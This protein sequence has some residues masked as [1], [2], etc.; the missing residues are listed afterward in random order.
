MKTFTHSIYT[1][2]RPWTDIPMGTTLTVKKVVAHSTVREGGGKF[3]VKRILLC[4]GIRSCKRG[5]CYSNHAC[6]EVTDAYVVPNETPYTGTHCVFAHNGES[7][8]EEIE[9]CETV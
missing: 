2:L 6:F 1:G 7:F 9:N 4:P 5:H 8:W 3:T